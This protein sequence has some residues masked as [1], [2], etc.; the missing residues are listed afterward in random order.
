MA[1]VILISHLMTNSGLSWALSQGTVV[2]Q[3]PGVSD[4]GS[5]QEWQSSRGCAW[6]CDSAPASLG[7]W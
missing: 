5:S 1:C 2:A 6:D 7:T 4:L 3:G